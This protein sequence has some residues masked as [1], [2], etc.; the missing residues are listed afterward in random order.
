[1][2]W[3]EARGVRWLEAD[4]PSATAVFST[5]SAGSAKESLIPLANALGI[6]LDRI[7]I[8]QHVHGAE[9]VFHPR[10][11]GDLP[12]ADGHVLVEPGVAGLVFVGDCLPV[13]VAGEGGVAILHCGW[14]GLAAGIVA[15]GAEAVNATHAAIGPGIG[16]CCYEVGGEVL[17]AFTGLGDGVA[18]GRMLDLP[19]VT[20]R[21]LRAA[22]VEE[23]ESAGICTSC[24][25]GDFFSYRRDG[26]AERQAGLAWRDDARG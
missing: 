4:L 25:E 9:L 16:P 22:G 24:E 12:K 23:I 18:A 1:M 19:E 2:R 5:R 26:R 6:A 11:E 20:R 21:L 17:N 15:R 3:V 7:A 14:R 10:P 8:A 13:A